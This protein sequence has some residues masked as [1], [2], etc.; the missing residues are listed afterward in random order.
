MGWNAVHDIVLHIPNICII[1]YVIV[2][3][4]VAFKLNKS[5]NKCW[6]LS[7]LSSDGH[8]RTDV[9]SSKGSIIIMYS[10][11]IFLYVWN[12]LILVLVG[13]R[14]NVKQMNLMHRWIKRT[15]DIS[16]EIEMR[17]IPYKST[18]VKVTILENCG[19]RSCINKIPKRFVFWQ[20][21]PLKLIQLNN[22]KNEIR[23]LTQ[24]AYL[25]LQYVNYL[26]KTS[27]LSKNFMMKLGLW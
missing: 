24:T 16:M 2:R 18:V 4:D 12:V 1:N 3:S 11:S 8:V 19:Q 10:C 27:Y 21:M 13:Q 17:E 20:K 26:N 5:E 9:R 14:S 15:H 7:F 25:Q 22:K 6:Q 23:V